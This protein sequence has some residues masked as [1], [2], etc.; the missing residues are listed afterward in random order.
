MPV[1]KE[2]I[3]YH[4]TGGSAADE[5]WVYLCFDSGTRQ[6]YIEKS[7]DYMF[8]G[9]KHPTRHNSGTEYYPADTWN[10]RGADKIQ[11]AKAALLAMAK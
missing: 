3:S 9:G 1:F 2:Q 11:A 10:G 4:S 8:Q 5:V 6:F 7:W